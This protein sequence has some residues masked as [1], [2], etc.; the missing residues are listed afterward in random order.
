MN[1]IH[2]FVLCQGCRKKTTI[3][4]KKEDNTKIAKCSFCLKIT[5]HQLKPQKNIWKIQSTN[6]YEN[7]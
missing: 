2:K 6:L 7:I 4:F 3:S 5:E 1:I